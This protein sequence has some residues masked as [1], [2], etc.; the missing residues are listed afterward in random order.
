MRSSVDYRAGCHYL[1]LMGHRLILT[2][3]AF[4][5]GSLSLGWAAQ[6][7]PA[8]ARASQVA[9]MHVGSVVE[10]AS[11]RT[12][13]APVALARL[14]EPGLRN[15]RRHAPAF[16]SADPLIVTAPAVLAGID[17]ARE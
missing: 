11:A 14:P 9:S 1:G 15:A 17:R 8:E 12:P 6:I 13:R 2:L 7:G 16:V 10:A 4:L 5:T 3:L